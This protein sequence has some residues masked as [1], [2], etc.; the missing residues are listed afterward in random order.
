MIALKDKYGRTL[1]ELEEDQFPLKIPIE[2]SLGEYKIYLNYKF[3]ETEG[4]KE[5]KV[6]S[7]NVS[8]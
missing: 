7:I 5:R 6:S 3:I 8:K 1:L 4:Q 2:T